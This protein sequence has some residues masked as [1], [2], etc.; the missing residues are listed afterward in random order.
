MQTYEVRALKSHGEVV[1]L[2][3]D[4]MHESDLQEKL[5]AQ[6]LL[7]VNA[8]KKSFTAALGGGASQFNLS[9]FT[10]EMIA[11]LNAGLTIVEAIETLVEKE[12][13][14]RA[15][16]VLQGLIGSLYEGRSFSVAL[17]Q[18][19]QIFPDLFIAN[20]RA[21]E[22]TGNL[23]ESLERY[24]SYD[25]QVQIIRKKIV[26]ASIYPMILLFVGGAVTLLLLG[27]V[28]PKFAALFENMKDLPITSRLLMSAGSFIKDN[29]LWSV[30]VFVGGFVGLLYGAFQPIV[31]QTFLS[32]LWKV[33]Y[34][35]DKLRIIE[36]S[37]F[38]RSLGMLLSSG[39]PIV[40][41][42]NMV[43]RLL[44]PSMRQPLLLAIA[45]ISTGMPLSKSL[46]K[47]QLTTP[48]SVR[49]LR[50]GE[51]S[52]RMGEMMERVSSFYDEDISRWV[53]FI[54]RLFEPI[55]MLLI[56]GVIGL[57]VISLYMPL[58]D[59]VGKVH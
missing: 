37:R 49:M 34:M 20:V 39:I 12:L 30:L 25:T 53:D 24:N 27:F 50:V 59:V 22:Q 47:H 43:S 54:T 41:A 6:G 4:A 16:Q 40:Q 35:R 15:K 58:F 18:F 21:S 36:L 33:S 45:D 57:V 3:L 23:V 10:Q 8:K 29:A 31:R 44:H 7:L 19:P 5:Q 55:L 46:E 51:Q 52:G 42:L 13:N 17:E 26:S 2:E 38:Y 1:V 11:L 48:V 28:V 9:L 56:G 14:E 32:V